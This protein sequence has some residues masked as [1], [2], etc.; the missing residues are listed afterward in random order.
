MACGAA[1]GAAAGAAGALL[2]SVGNAAEVWKWKVTE[3]D[4]YWNL[5]DGHVS[6]THLTFQLPLA[7]DG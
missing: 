7:P 4:A 5:R 6:V 3:P 2:G 1:V